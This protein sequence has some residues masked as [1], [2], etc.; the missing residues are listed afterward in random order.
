MI[1][2][3]LS[4]EWFAGVLI[5]CADVSE[6]SV[7][8]TF[9][10]GVRTTYEDGTDVFWNSAQNPLLGNHPKEKIQLIIFIDFVIKLFIRGLYNAMSD[11]K[12]HRYTTKTHLKFSTVTGKS[13]NSSVGTAIR[14]QTGQPK[15]K[16]SIPL[17]VRHYSRHQRSRLAIGHTQPIIQ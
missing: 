17:G 6:H 4:F 13:N 12:R 14:L 11:L 1:S 3:I 7:S 16:G 5:W 8:S 15:N 10:G 9:T 2:C